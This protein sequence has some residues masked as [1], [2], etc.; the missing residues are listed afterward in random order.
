M[1]NAVKIKAES[2]EVQIIQHA[3]CYAAGLW[4]LKSEN[5]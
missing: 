1:Q 3:V 4:G 5:R 2:H